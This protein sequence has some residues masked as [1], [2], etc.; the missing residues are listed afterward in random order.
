MKVFKQKLDKG[1]E[2]VA[3]SEEGV[4]QMTFKVPSNILFYENVHVRESNM[5]QHEYFFS[6]GTKKTQS[7]FEVTPGSYHQRS[8]TKGLPALRGGGDA[9]TH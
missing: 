5:F 6:K 2:A 9:F 7:A 8:E 4:K 1:D 3:S